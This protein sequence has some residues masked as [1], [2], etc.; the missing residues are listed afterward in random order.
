MANDPHSPSLV[1]GLDSLLPLPA[2]KVAIP[3]WQAVTAATVSPVIA[4]VFTNPFDVAKVKLQLQV[5]H[6]ALAST[7]V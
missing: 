4:C 7:V 2:H 6:A 3:G 5:R 1:A